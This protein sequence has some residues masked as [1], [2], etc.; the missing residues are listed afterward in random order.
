MDLRKEQ[1]LRQLYQ[2]QIQTAIQNGSLLI[3]HLSLD[4]ISSQAYPGFTNRMFDYKAIRKPFD[5]EPTAL[6]FGPELLRKQS[7]L[8]ST[9]PVQSQLQLLLILQGLRAESRHTKYL[10]LAQLISTKHYGSQRLSHQPLT[11]LSFRPSIN[12]FYLYLTDERPISYLLFVAKES[13]IILSQKISLNLPR[14]LYIVYQKTN[15]Q[16]YGRHSQIT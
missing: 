1:L 12:P 13:I 8:K 3:L 14:A 11:Y 7:S 5:S 15:S 2:I 6:L 10:L 4:T 16:Y 9:Y